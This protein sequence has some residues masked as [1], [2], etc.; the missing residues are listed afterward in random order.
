[1]NI[2]ILDDYHDT[3][4]TLKCFSK[5]NGNSVQIWHEHTK[6]L[7]VLEERLKDSEV[8][9]LIRERTP[10]PAELVQRLPKLRLISQRGPFPHIDIE[11]CTRAGVVVSSNMHLA[12][13]SYATAELT[14]ALVLMSLRDIPNQMAALKA[15]N[16]QAGMG[17]A[18]RGRK[19]GIYSFGRI[20][21]VVAGYARAFGMQVEVW[22]RAASLEK[23]RAAGYAVAS[24]RESFFE[25]CDVISL[26]LPLNEETRGIVTAEDLSRMRPDAVI[27][28]TSRAGLFGSGVLEGALR[29][30]RPGLAAIDVYEEEPL[31]NPHHA[32]LNMGNVIATPHIGYVERDAYESQ[33][34]DIFDQIIAFEQGRPINVVNPAALGQPARSDAEVEG[35]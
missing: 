30:G 20:G 6:D 16:W 14:W 21:G 10:V 19:L 29:A 2:A 5:L 8:L 17:R 22:G 28:N 26:H 13:P 35:K 9:V 33:F 11:T 24:S 15:G 7:G 18:L 25:S 3:V 12:E 31:T 1:M 27:V 34:A 32:L 4:R 23:A